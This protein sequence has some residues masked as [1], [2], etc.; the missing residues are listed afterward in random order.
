MRQLDIWSTQLTEEQKNQVLRDNFST[1]NKFGQT[2]G[3]NTL[4][5]FNTTTNF[6]TASASFVSIPSFKGAFKSSGGFIIIAAVLSC[7][8]AT[9]PSGVNTQM[10]VD[11]RNLTNI[12]SYGPAV[13]VP[14]THFNAGILNAGSHTIDFQFKASSGTASINPNGV[15]TSSYYVIEF[16]KG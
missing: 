1:L 5:S 12:A 6:V 10:V 16:A 2:L 3:M 11:G 14:H 8:N 15:E 4:L 9:N 7:Y 13:Q